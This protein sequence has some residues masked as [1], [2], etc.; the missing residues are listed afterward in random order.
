MLELFLVYHFVADRVTGPDTTGAFASGEGYAH[1]I[2][3]AKRG[4]QRVQVIV[5]AIQR[6]R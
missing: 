5:S 3:F 2:A 1:E 4:I 6:Q